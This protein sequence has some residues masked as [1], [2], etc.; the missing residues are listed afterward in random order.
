MKR[1]VSACAA[2]LLLCQ[3]VY[4]ADSLPVNWRISIEPEAEILLVNESGTTINEG[5]NI[6]M[7]YDLSVDYGK[8]DVYVKWDITSSENLQ[9][10]ANPENMLT[11]GT[12]TIDWGVQ[13]GDKPLN[14]IFVS[15]NSDG[16]SIYQHTGVNSLISSNM[17]DTIEEWGHLV[18]RTEA[19]S[20]RTDLADGSYKANL[21]IGIRSV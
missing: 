13:V 19:L 14:V 15:D 20:L 17:D 18:L 10:F 5:S 16:I 1:I 2:I 3:I 8:T 4:S 9:I 7:S 6:S 12:H 11:D 21:I